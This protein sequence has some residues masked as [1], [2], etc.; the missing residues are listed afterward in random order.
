MQFE[1]VLKSPIGEKMGRE[2]KGKREFSSE[3]PNQIFN[4]NV[5]KMKY[6]KIK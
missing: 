1:L 5:V 4:H 3:N 2:K 6:F